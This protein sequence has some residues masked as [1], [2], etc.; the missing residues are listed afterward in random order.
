MEKKDL[1]VVGSGPGGMIA[2][3]RAAAGG[4]KVT[5]VEESALG[6][7][8]LNEGC[9]PS[10]TLLHSAKIYS[11]AL[12]GEAFG[13]HAENVTFDLLAVQRR[14]QKILETLRGGIAGLMKKHKVEV[15]SGRARLAGRG[16]VTVNGQRL[17][18]E[19]ILLA[20]GSI[21]ARP[22]LE[23]LDLPGVLDSTGILLLEQL[24]ARLVIIGG[25]IIGCEFA[26]FFASLGVPVTVIEMLP[27]ICPTLDGEVAA[28]LRMELTRKGIEFHT[29]SRVLAIEEDAVVF[30]SGQEKKR[31][32]WDRVLV[33]TGRSVRVGDLGLEEARVEFDRKGIR[34]DERG[35]TNVPGIWA[36]GDVTGRGWL[37]HAASRMG[38]VVVKNLLGQRDRMRF[39][40]V[41]SVVYT[42]P[43]VA[44]VGWTEAEAK[45]QGMETL[46]AKFPLTANGRF[47]AEHQGSRG[48]AKVVVEKGSRRLV[49]VHVIGGACSEMIW[50][51]AVAVEAELR[52]QDLMDIVFP[53]PTASESIRD[54]LFYLPK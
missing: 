37:A 5:L 19:H 31:A 41:P 33:A 52:V 18:A 40:A 25:G 50:G 49:G 2:A 47:L 27:E 43:E 7:V 23:G 8:C 9:I 11:L 20:T 51:A 48:F 21:P 38:E 6:G 4:L 12:H 30:E 26:C 54:A 10:K 14:K 28:L 29:N 3:E 46:T 16:A 53:H 35:A 1:I 39:D 36:C 13:V 34:V 45:K 22:P 44:A 42:S 17:E 24:P 32:P 15:V